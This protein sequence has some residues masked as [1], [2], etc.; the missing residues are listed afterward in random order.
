M[1]KKGLK[2]TPLPNLLNLANSLNTYTYGTF[3]I[4]IEGST[5]GQDPKVRA[6][7]R[8][9]H[10]LSRKCWNNGLL[11]DFFLCRRTDEM[12]TFGMTIEMGDGLWDVAMDSRTRNGVAT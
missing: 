5:L 2:S 10:H 4:F 3:H 8:K 6:L 12:M 7:V 9:A 1:A 11:R